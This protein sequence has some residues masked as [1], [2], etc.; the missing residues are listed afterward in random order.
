MA[1]YANEDVLV[2]TEWVASVAAHPEAH[3]NVRIVE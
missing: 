2:S 3:P 1:S